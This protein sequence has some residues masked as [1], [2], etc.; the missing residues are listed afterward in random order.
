MPQRKRSC[1]HKSTPKLFQCK[2]FGNCNMVFT[3]SEH[4]ARHERKHTGEKPYKCIVASCGRMFS[5][6]DNMMQHTQTHDKNKKRMRR[7]SETNEFN[8]V[9]FDSPNGSQQNSE[10]QNHHQQQ[11]RKT[12]PEIAMAT[13]SENSMLHNRIL[14]PLR[15][16]TYSDPPVGYGNYQTNYPY[17]VPQSPIHEKY[18]P[19][20]PAMFRSY[21]PR[22]SPLNTPEKRYSWPTFRGPQEFPFPEESPNHCPPSFGYRRRSST[23]T[24]STDTSVLTS[25]SHN[26]SDDHSTIPSNHFHIRRRISIDDLR[27]PIEDLQSIQ[28]NQKNNKKLCNYSDKQAVD[29]TS[30]EYEALEGLSKFHSKNTVSDIPISVAQENTTFASQVCALRQRVMTL[31]ESFQRPVRN[32]GNDTL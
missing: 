6:F 31:K 9:E 14:P 5:R 21:Q 16:G 19:I 26:P 22:G 15:R 2:G 8:E 4:L 3:R 27:T 24:A 18:N 28:F 12:V 10:W 25:T 23:S 11:Q 17:S 13:L 30:D 1:S 29:I 20:P 7:A 32:I